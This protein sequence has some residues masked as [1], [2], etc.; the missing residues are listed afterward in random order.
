ML[1]HWKNKIGLFCNVLHQEGIPYCLFLSD[2]SAKHREG[3][4]I[5]RG[6]DTEWVSFLQGEE[7]T[8]ASSAHLLL[9]L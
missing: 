9:E 7:K 4:L 3:D 1:P 2:F 6:R 5:I 8:E